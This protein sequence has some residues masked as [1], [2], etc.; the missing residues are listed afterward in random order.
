LL[1]VLRIKEKIMPRNNKNMFFKLKHM[2]LRVFSNISLRLLR[3]TVKKN[4]ITTTIIIILIGLKV[5][6][7]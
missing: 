2:L 6:I 3:K 5:T 4:L 7:Q 1:V